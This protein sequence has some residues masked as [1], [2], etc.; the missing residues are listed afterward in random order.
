M[1]MLNINAYTEFEY[2][3]RHLCCIFTLNQFTYIVKSRF[4]KARVP[5]QLSPMWKSKL[6]ENMHRNRFQSNVCSALLYGGSSW[7]LRSKLDWKVHGSNTSMLRLA[8]KF[9]LEGS[10]DQWTIV[11]SSVSDMIKE[12]GARITG[13]SKRIKDEIFSKVLLWEP[14][15]GRARRVRQGK[16]YIMTT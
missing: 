13:Q 11:L 7:T 9:Q 5:R 10:T 15:Q 1:Q 4:L 6:P 2:Y 12:R 3:S 14:T 16:T 8:F